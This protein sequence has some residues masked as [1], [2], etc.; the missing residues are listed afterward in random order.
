MISMFH[1]STFYAYSIQSGR[2]H[3]KG[4]CF[5]WHR[6]QCLSI[7]LPSIAHWH[8]YTDLDWA[9][10]GWAVLR[11]AGLGCTVLRSSGVQ[12]SLLD[13]FG[14]ACSVLG[15][16]VLY[17]A[18][19]GWAVLPLAQLFWAVRNRNIN[20]K[21]VQFQNKYLFTNNFLQNKMLALTDFN[22]LVYYFAYDSINT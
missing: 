21:Y 1:L 16:A 7:C 10:I 15:S 19:L 6:Q 8:G 3:Y 2:L 9:V 11:C 17:G 20:D 4:K 12:C 13:T 14:L 5:Q 22:I 18:F